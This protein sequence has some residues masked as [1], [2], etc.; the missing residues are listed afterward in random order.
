[1][2]FLTSLKPYI[3]KAYFG[4]ARPPVKLVKIAIGDGAIGSAIEFELLPA[5]SVIETYPQ[6]I[7]YNT[8]IYN[9]FKEQ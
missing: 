8:D 6:L 4:M 3:T 5:L 2:T 7:G 1:M 9:Y